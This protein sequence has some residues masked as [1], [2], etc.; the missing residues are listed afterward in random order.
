MDDAESSGSCA[1]GRGGRRRRRRAASAS[2]RSAERRAFSDALGFTGRRRLGQGR[3]GNVAGSHKAR[4]LFGML[5]LLEV[6]ERLG[7]ADPTAPGHR[8]LWQRR[9]RRCR[10]RRAAGWRARRIRAGRGRPR[11]RGRLEELG[12]PSRSAHAAPGVAGDPTVRRLREAVAAGALPFSC[13][14]NRQ[15]PRDRRRA[16][17]RL[18]DGRG[19]RHAGDEAT[20]PALH[21]GRWRRSGLRTDP[22]L[23]DARRWAS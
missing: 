1:T 21:P 11:G 4:H 19:A 9:A 17:A 6:A 16:D 22:G 13:Q 14:G 23:G 7:L 2:R 3:D 10:R 18:R 15:R 8:E 12:A 5:H 20:R